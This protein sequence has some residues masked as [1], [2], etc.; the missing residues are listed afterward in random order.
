MKICLDLRLPAVKQYID[1]LH[2][3][4]NGKLSKE[5]IGFAWNYW[6]RIN[7]R[8]IDKIPTVENIVD[9]YTELE[10]LTAQDEFN[11]T[12]VT[13]KQAVIDLL[14]SLYFS[15]MEAL[16]GSNLKM[17]AY[18]Y[19]TRMGRFL[20]RFSSVLLYILILGIM[21]DQFFELEKISKFLS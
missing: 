14:Q 20:Y 13:D 7:K 2:T 18:F 5:N 19:Q 16:A 15:F 11:K 8:N 3:E 9:S 6:Y 17:P 4:L 10:A 21:L 1:K 12:S